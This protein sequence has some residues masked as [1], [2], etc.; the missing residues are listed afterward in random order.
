MS[1]VFRSKH[2]VLIPTDVS[3]TEAMLFNNPVPIP[4]DK[5]IFE[6]AHTS[7]TVSYLAF[8]NQVRRTA[9]W[10][11]SHLGLAAGDI[12]TIVSASSIDYIVASHAVWWLGG[13]VSMINDALSPKDLAY[14]LDLVQPKFVIIGPS[15][16]EK[17]TSSFRLSSHA[18]SIRHLVTI[19][20]SPSYPYWAEASAAAASSRGGDNAGL[21]G[22]H[23]SLKDSD[24]RNVLAAVVLSSGTTGRSKAVMMSRHNLIAANYQLRADNPQNWRHDMREVFF[25]PLSHVYATYVVMTGAPEKRRWLV[26]CLQLRRC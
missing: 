13:V 16:V 22:E 24:N 11:H 6:E 3:V 10:L 23:F 20:R 18:E 25:P 8:K 15:A 4:G 26:W 21:A 14:G 1:Q 19:G 12:V 9:G 2:R 5:V 17:V 7:R